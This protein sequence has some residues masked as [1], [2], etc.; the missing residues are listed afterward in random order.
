[1][2]LTSADILKVLTDPNMIADPSLLPAAW[3]TGPA[4]VFMLFM[5]GLIPIGVIFARDAGVSWYVTLALYAFSDIFQPLVS[6]PMVMLFM[7]MGRRV[8][9]LGRIGSRIGR[10]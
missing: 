3:P 8:P 10:F 6:E 5:F 9:V 1:M 2:E 7:W 4:G